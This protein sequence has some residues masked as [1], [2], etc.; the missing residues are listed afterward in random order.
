[1]ASDKPITAAE[2]AEWK[3]SP[4]RLRDAWSAIAAH[5]KTPT[6][7]EVLAFFEIER[8]LD[9]A[10]EALPRL[11]DEVARLQRKAASYREL[12]EAFAE[13]GGQSE[14]CRLTLD[15]VDEAANAQ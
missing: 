10:R 7:A 12:C 15:A 9:E 14:A 8:A 4:N 2:L 3:R 13:H 5:V 6:Q 11:V 1:M